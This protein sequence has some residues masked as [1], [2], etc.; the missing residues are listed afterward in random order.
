M[1]TEIVPLTFLIGPTDMLA[2]D[3]VLMVEEL[4]QIRVKPREGI[5]S[6]EGEAVLLV[7]RR[8]VNGGWGTLRG[9]RFY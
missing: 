8:E 3:E 5:T 4:S 7:S 2:T 9:G 6:Q 1:K